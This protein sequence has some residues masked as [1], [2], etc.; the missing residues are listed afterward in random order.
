MQFVK[1]NAVLLALVLI[2]LFQQSEI[3][4]ME[5]TLN[6][7]YSAVQK[8]NDDIQLV[9]DEIWAIDDILISVHSDAETVD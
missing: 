5:R 3:R 6:Y 7:I 1:S 9:R 2:V 8:N 4:Q